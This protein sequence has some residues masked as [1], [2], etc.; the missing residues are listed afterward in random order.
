MQET[1]YYKLNKSALRTLQKEFDANP[2]SDMLDILQKVALSYSRFRSELDARRRKRQGT[3]C[4]YS[5][6]R[7]SRSSEP[8]ALS[9]SKV[10]VALNDHVVVKMRP[11]LRFEEFG[12]LQFLHR[13]VPAVIAPRALGYMSVGSISCLFMTRIPGRPLDNCWG[14]LSLQ[15]K[16]SVKTL[17]ND[18]LS[19]LRLIHLPTGSL[20]GSV[21][22]QPVCKDCRRHTRISVSPIANESQFNDF[23]TSSETSRAS[24]GYRNWVLSMM[25]NDHKILLTH[26]DLHPGNIIIDTDDNGRISLG[27]VD[28]EMGGFYPEYWEMLKALNTRSIRDPSDWWDCLPS[29]LVGYPCEIAIDRMIENTLL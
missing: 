24:V 28:W 4:R 9:G 21:L 12:L 20:M 3:T 8:L 19:N 1:G 26:G 11:N 17:L 6:V 16:Q 23:I 14:T 22:D 10:I 13:Q 7:C 29:A 18:M 2:E 5:I 15:E 25:R 27:L